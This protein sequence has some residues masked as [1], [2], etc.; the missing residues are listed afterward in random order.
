MTEASQH[1]LRHF[2]SNYFKQPILI[3]ASDFLARM[4]MSSVHHRKRLTFKDKNIVI[5][6]ILS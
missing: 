6:Q 1:L 4:I 3:A 2:S 5:K